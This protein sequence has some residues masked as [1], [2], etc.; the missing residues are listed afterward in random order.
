MSL[1]HVQEQAVAAKAV[2]ILFPL[3]I[4]STHKAAA[5]CLFLVTVIGSGEPLRYEKEH[6]TDMGKSREFDR[7]GEADPKKVITK[8][9]PL[10]LVPIMY[11]VVSILFIVA[12]ILWWRS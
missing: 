10:G 3:I 1:I 11:I 6:E 4:K 12:A 2:I 5:Y 7:D 9:G 8:T